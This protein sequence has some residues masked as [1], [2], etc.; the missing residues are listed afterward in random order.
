MA[1]RSFYNHDISISIC[2][3]VYF[4]TGVLETQELCY[5]H[6]LQIHGNILVLVHRLWNLVSDSIFVDDLIYTLHCPQGDFTGHRV[7]ADAFH[8]VL[9]A[10]PFLRGVFVSLHILNP[11]G[12]A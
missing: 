5:Y 10:L 2:F 7:V 12:F 9:S 3:N 11:P 6:A 4:G 8:G 1:T